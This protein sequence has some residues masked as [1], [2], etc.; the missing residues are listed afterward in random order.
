MTKGSLEKWRS[1]AGHS[2]GGM[3]SAWTMVAQGSPSTT[4]KICIEN[5]FLVPCEAARPSLLLTLPPCYCLESLPLHK[6]ML[7]ASASDEKFAP[8][9]RPSVRPSS[10][11]SAPLC[12]S[13]RPLCCVACR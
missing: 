13:V 1:V 11:H 6:L 7:F 2:F 3:G 4:Q 8:S 5:D 12:P 10:A 9:V